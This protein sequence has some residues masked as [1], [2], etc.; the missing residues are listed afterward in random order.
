MTIYQ[1]RDCH[2]AGWGIVMTNKTG[3]YLIR[4]FMTEELA[5]FT[6]KYLNQQEE[7]FENRDDQGKS[8]GEELT[9]E[10]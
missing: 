10:K 5:K 3:E 9:Y 2:R 7:D 6:A 8:I 1:A 4:Q